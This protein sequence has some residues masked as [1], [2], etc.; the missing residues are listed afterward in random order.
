[1]DKPK[2]LKPI[3]WE[4]YNDVTTVY[5]NYN[6][7]CLEMWNSSD[8]RKNIKVCGW[9]FQGHLG[10]PINIK[11]FTLLDKEANIFAP[12]PWVGNG[13]GISING[14][15]IAD[16]LRN[17]FSTVDITKKCCISGELYYNEFADDACC[18]TAPEIIMNDIYFE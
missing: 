3:D 7:D 4:N 5:W 11:K 8:I 15:F 6:K 14:Y 1:M 12:N 10:E 16:S 18:W 2:D 9:I 13:V 17:K